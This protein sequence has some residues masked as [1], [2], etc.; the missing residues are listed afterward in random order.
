MSDISQILPGVTASSDA[1][2]WS[3]TYPQENPD[4]ISAP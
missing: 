3:V 1:V 4:K 2:S